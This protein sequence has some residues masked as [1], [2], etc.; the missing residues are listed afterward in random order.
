MINIGHDPV[1][2]AV[3]LLAL[4]AFTYALLALFALVL[5]L[6]TEAGEACRDDGRGAT[7]A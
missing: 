1:G 5:M 2:P 7:A 6:P 4:S 3:N